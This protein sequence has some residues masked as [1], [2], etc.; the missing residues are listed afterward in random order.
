VL[1]Q[2]ISFTDF[3]SGELNSLSWY[4]LLPG[5]RV[6]VNLEG[7]VGTAA[8]IAGDILFEQTTQSVL[9]HFWLSAMA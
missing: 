9:E 1:T 8:E 4:D 6:E 2:K 7:N 5:D 3:N